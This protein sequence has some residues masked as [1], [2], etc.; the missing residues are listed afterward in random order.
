MIARVYRSGSFA[1]AVQYCQ[2][3]AV[4]ERALGSSVLT[5]DPKGPAEREVIREFLVVNE[6]KEAARPVVHIP[7]RT[8]D[9]EH[10]TEEQWLQVAE[11]VRTEMGYENCPW[12]AYLHNNEG[13]REGQHVHLVLSRV[14]FDGKIVSD[15]FERYRVMEVMRGLERDLG[16][17]P[18]L[19]RDRNQP[20][21]Y[22]HSAVGRERERELI[23]LRAHIDAAGANARTLSGFI[24]R[25]EEAGVRVHLKISVNGHL[26]G[27]SF[28]LGGSDR[29]WKGSDLGRAYS[30]GRLVQRYELAQEGE[31]LRA[32][33]LRPR[34]L[35]H[36]RS[37]GLTPDRVE[38]SEG[39]RF[40]VAWSLV[41]GPREQ[42]AYQQWVQAAIPGRLCERGEA[43]DWS[44]EVPAA[45][46][47]ARRQQIEAALVERGRSSP[48]VPHL[49][50]GPQSLRDASQQV[51][52]LLE[53]YSRD[54]RSGESAER[55]SATWLEILRW[56]GVRG[57]RPEA[58]GQRGLA[59]QLASLGSIAQTPHAIRTRL[60]RGARGYVSMPAVAGELTYFPPHLLGTERGPAHR[61]Y[62]RQANQILLER[63]SVALLRVADH[64]GRTREEHR[65]RSRLESRLAEVERAAVSWG[66]RATGRAVRP[67][68]RVENA[69]AARRHVSRRLAGYLRRTERGL[70]RG[71]VSTARSLGP[72]SP[73]NRLPGISL[74]RT[75][76]SMGRAIGTGV[77]FASELGQAVFV[78]E[79]AVRRE[80][81]R[82]SRRGASHLEHVAAGDISTYRLLRLT[83]GH[84]RAVARFQAPQG[85]PR[86][87]KDAIRDYR[88]SRAELVRFARAS[89]REGRPARDTAR[90]AAHRAAAVL[91]AREQVVNAS[92]QRLG[93]PSIRMLSGTSRETAEVLA[94]FAQ[95]CRTA[96]LSVGT[97]VRVV[98]EVGPVVL[99]SV[100][101][102]AALTLASRLVMRQVFGIGRDLAKEFLYGERER[103]R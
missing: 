95:S 32:C 44:R 69:V 6:A 35:A 83:S 74:L 45:V 70:A 81:R 17:E 10:L 79:A 98:A 68:A 34:E 58:L 66:G 23:M 18:V 87:L 100:V 28:E 30:I 37:A 26:Q 62:N 27:A 84:P 52:A 63:E 31:V 85:P 47:E 61:D 9:G 92:L 16:L 91:A 97:A 12:A 88:R 82:A 50:D 7:V 99:G 36:L 96:G 4:G 25:L 73:L 33:E 75:A 15:K 51:E 1:N 90:G 102:G 22:P 11:R 3:K 48:P 54:L 49:A 39:G 13:G 41:G 42:D 14:T 20:R 24:E 57:V 76:R 53:R 21:L 19:S 80:V 77:G 38:S 5:N 64:L 60:E 29:I 8:R 65:L 86:E 71:V 40:T 56:T 101:A 67:P 94:R 72:R 55:L 89:V 43:T 46:L 93:I 103:G 2:G 78:I 59:Q